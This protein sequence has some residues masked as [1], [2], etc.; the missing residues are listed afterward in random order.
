MRAA[1]ATSLSMAAV[2]AQA[3]D[4]APLRVDTLQIMAPGV[5]TPP[6]RVRV[7][8][9]PT[10]GAGTQPG[11]DALYVDDGQDA[12]AVHLADTVM[13]LA[14][15]GTIRAP[16]VVAIDMPPDR[17]GAYGFSDR[18]A[19][20]AVVSPTKYGDVGAR[21]HAYSEWL[22]HTLV[23]FVESRYAVRPSPEARA[24]LGW[25]LG[26]AHAFNV[27]WQ[28]PEVFAR[29][30]AFSPSFWLST[31]RTRPDTQQRTRI[32][33]SMV[34]STPP[35]N[36]A[37]F[38]FAIGTDEE[39][40]DRDGDGVNDAVD[41]VRD[42][43]DGWNVDAGGMKGLKQV[44][45]RVNDDAAH[46]A[47]RSDVA[48]YVL[49][50]GKH[51]Q[52]SWAQMLPP[53]LRWA[54]A[55]H[56][57]ALNATGHTESWQELPSR[58]VVARNVDVWLPP[59]YGRDPKRRYPVLYMHDGQNLFDPTLSYTTGVDWD[60]DGAMTRLIATHRVR[61]AIVVGVWNT[62]LRFAEYMPKAPVARSS[63]NV[64][65]DGIPPVD[66]ATLRSDDYVRYLAEELKPFIDAHYRTKTA[67]ADTFVMGSSMGGLISLYALAQRPD[68]FGG[69]GAVSTHWPAAN[70]ASVDWFASHLPRAGTHRIYFDHGTRTLDAEYAPFQQRIDAA[71][72][73]LGYREGR[74]VLSRVY[75]GAEHNEAA[76][77][78]R[79]DLP[80]Q[81]LLGPLR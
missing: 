50:G 15:A 60:V 35:R 64:G 48:L 56:A 73:A 52:A 81:F 41:D 57:P 66:A 59:S 26:G 40:S 4:V 76:W 68:V 13:S 67:P 39:T 16:V 17:M 11:C 30:G 3:A 6:L 43:V 75:E 9:P 8:V 44:G 42:V 63:I 33:Q 5:S 53:F 46:R 51:Q 37:R 32:A 47:D 58:F 65:V 28:Y 54:Y 61:E 12:E 71:M 7:F 14:S 1:F 34:A 22:V 18:A 79:V 62:P 69:A 49:D 27:G 77:K 38:F 19:G 23:P 72:P 74:D 24:I 29:V 55:V 25:S 2:A 31:D 45:Y 78:A 36:G 80:L 10:C 21:A 70:G 20:K